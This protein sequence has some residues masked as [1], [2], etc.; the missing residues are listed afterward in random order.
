MHIGKDGEIDW[1]TLDRSN[2]DIEYSKLLEF[3]VKQAA[4][5]FQMDPAEINWTTGPAGATTN[6]ESGNKDKQTMSQKRGLEPLLTFLSN[7]F[8]THVVCR[9]DPTYVMEFVGMKRGRSADSEIREREVKSFRT[10]N[11]I[12]V[13][14]GLDEKP[15][16]D[17]LLSVLLKETE[18]AAMAA[19]GE[20]DDETKLVDIEREL[21]G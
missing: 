17:V 11:E 8:N 19:T 20:N 3:L 7:Q 9:F 16:G 12:R 6:F 13:E 10:I 14:L 15:W 5:V 1:V 18:M 2:R 21:N 4:G